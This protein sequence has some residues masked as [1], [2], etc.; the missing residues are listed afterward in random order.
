MASPTSARGADGAEGILRHV[1]GSEDRDRGEE[2]MWLD[3]ARGVATTLVQ[4]LNIEFAA[5]CRCPHNEV[6]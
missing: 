3:E 5:I 1:P 6:G 4:F 2:T